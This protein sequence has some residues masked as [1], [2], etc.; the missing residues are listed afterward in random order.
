MSRPIQKSRLRRFALIGAAFLALAV[1]AV[2]V[3]HRFACPDLHAFDP[4]IAGRMESAMW[5][6]YYD[7]H[8]VRLGS[9]TMQLACGQYGLS[10]WDGARMSAHAAAAA[11]HFR[12]NMDDPRC[13]DELVSYYR[14]IQHG[15]PSRL[16][17]QNLAR[18]E[19]QWWRE[20][21]Q[22]VPPEGYAGTIAQLTGSIYGVEEDVV[23]PAAK[24]RTAAMAYR[25][26]RRNGKM[27]EA[28]WAE[29]SKQLIEAYTVLKKETAAQP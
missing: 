12:K 17:V 29:V 9:Q 28:D 3:Q 2:A 19:L 23:L 6:S 16:D 27:T 4:Q 1:L 20:R 18:L 24:L 26:A 15:V 10:W 13:L 25:D 11:M 7:G 22:N 14:I 5:R 8:W 21:R